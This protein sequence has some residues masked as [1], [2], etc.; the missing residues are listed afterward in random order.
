MHLRTLDTAM[1]CQLAAP[2]KCKLH[3]LFKQ[4]TSVC[5]NAMMPQNFLTL[6]NFEFPRNQVSWIPVVESSLSLHVTEIFISYHSFMLNF[7]VE[8]CF[9]KILQRSGVFFL[10]CVSWLPRKPIKSL[11]AIFSY[12]KLVTIPYTQFAKT[13]L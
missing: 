8:T 5:R 11:I 7:K 1:T 10:N 2:Y 12:F 6:I 9:R 3:K 4:C 13:Y